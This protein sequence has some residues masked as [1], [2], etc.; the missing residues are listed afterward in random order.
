[1]RCSGYSTYSKHLL[2]VGQFVN[3]VLSVSKLIGTNHKYA[4]IGDRPF[5]SV[6]VLYGM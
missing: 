6:S 2:V 3:A 1:M 5:F 4:R